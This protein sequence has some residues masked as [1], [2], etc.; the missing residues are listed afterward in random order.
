ME[1][2]LDIS[3]ISSNKPIFTY[4]SIAL[5]VLF[6]SNFLLADSASIFGLVMV[7]TLVN[8]TYVWN[9]ITSCFFETNVI[10]LAFDMIALWFITGQ[11]TSTPSIE[12]FGFYFGFSVLFCT[13]STSVV[14]FIYFAMTGNDVLITRSIYGFNG[15]LM[16]LLMFSRQQKR[17]ESVHSSVPS[18]TFHHLPALLLTVQ[19]VAALFKVT[20]IS[21]DLPFT[22]AAF[23]SSWSYLRFYYKFNDTDYGDKGEDFS[24]VGMFPEV[25]LLPFV[26]L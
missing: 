8:N 11:T 19:V 26:V 20:V 12:Q 7:N 15:V 2:S 13:M 16:A 22:V 24:F 25:P 1:Q 6:G 10:K 3:N 21:I 5:L 17:S 23:F 18:I 4:V 14:S 9:M